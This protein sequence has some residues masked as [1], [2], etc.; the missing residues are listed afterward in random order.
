MTGIPDKPALSDLS[1]AIART[2]VYMTYNR[3]ERIEVTRHIGTTG[4]GALTRPLSVVLDRP[5]QNGLVDR[6]DRCHPSHITAVTLT[7]SSLPSDKGFGGVFYVRRQ[8]TFTREHLLGAVVKLLEYMQAKD[9]W[10][11][12][13]THKPGINAASLDAPS[14][15]KVGVEDTGAS[16]MLADDAAPDYPGLGGVFFVYP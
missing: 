7:D 12:I 1:V 11:L 13:V 8:S 14:N 16:T 5:S 3:V 10:R 2:L 15:T 9:I 4:P 6:L